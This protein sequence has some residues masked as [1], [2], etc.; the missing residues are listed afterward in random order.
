MCPISPAVSMPC[1]E[2]YETP[3]CCVCVCDG[4]WTCVCGAIVPP[5]FWPYVVVTTAQSD[6]PRCC[7][8]ESIFLI[9]T[10]SPDVPA[11]VSLSVSARKFLD[12]SARESVFLDVSARLVVSSCGCIHVSAYVRNV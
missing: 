2:V 12:T 8:H 11:R 10:S 7:A 6:M 1:P 3:F 5:E 4:L 9:D